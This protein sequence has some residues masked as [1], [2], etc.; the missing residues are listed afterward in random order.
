MGSSNS[1]L[2]LLTITEESLDEGQGM[3][4]LTYSTQLIAS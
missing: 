1:M 2:E 3:I 4:N